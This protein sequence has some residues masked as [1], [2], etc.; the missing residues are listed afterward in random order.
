MDLPRSGVSGEKRAKWGAVM[1]SFADTYMPSGSGG[2]V[3]MTHRT[4]G[5]DEASGLARA[6]VAGPEDVFRSEYARLVRTLTVIAGEREVAADAVQES[7]VRLIR[8][9]D[10]ICTYEDPVGWVRRVAVNQIRDHHRAL[11]RRTKLLQRIEQQSAPA[12]Y[13]LA[14]DQELW[15]QLRSLPER[16]R[17]VLA[18]HYVGDLTGRE[19]AEVMKVS[20]GT[21]AR[22]LYRALQTLGGKFGEA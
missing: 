13:V 10:K 7:F 17:T 12:D 14:T 15:E 18:L 19:V 21:V 4:A 11:G 20:E 2:A 1:L 9:W 22:H 5:G 8:R 3:T 6:S 16:Q